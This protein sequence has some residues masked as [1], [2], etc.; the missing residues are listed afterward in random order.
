MPA[1]LIA[2]RFG[3]RGPNM[4][5]LTACAASSQ[6]IGEAS[7]IIRRGD[8][9]VMLTGGAHSML[10]PFGLGGFNL[11]TA[12]SRRNDDPKRASRPFDRDRDGFVLSEGA[13]MLVL[14]E[15][16][17]ALARGAEIY[18]EVAGYGTTGD[19][20]RVTDMHPEGR[21]AKSS[22]RMALSDAG[23]SPEKIDYINTH[24]TS[25]AVNDRVETIAIKDV[26]GDRAAKVPISSIK[27][28]LGHL[29]AGA[30][31]MEAI[32]CLFAIRDGIIPPT[33]NYE[34]PDGQLDLDYVPNEARKAHLDY[35]MSNSFGFGGQ[36]V[37]LIIARYPL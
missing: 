23:L 18:G 34:N 37:V 26:F 28:M 5:C 32:A 20:Y 22:M 1:G 8:A 11:L 4:S 29:I 30:G 31:A 19:A 15:L 25:T 2:G 36:N 21:S 17:H 6:A 24:G 27:S 3:A 9:D 35:C 14:E 33:I 16:D 13:A 7:M 10:H 12:L